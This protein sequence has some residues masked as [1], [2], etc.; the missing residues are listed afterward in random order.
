MKISAIIITKNEE[1]Q[2]TGCIDSLKFTDEIVVID[3]NSQ[4]NTSQ[5]AK[6]LGAKVYQ[7]GGLDF[8]YLRNYARE[9][10]KNQWLLYVDADERVSEEL[11]SEMIT[12]LEEKSYTAYRLKRSNFFLGRRWP[13]PEEMIRLIRKDSLIGWQGVLHETA[14]VTG[15]TGNLDN[16]LLHF[17]HRNLADMAE[18]TNQWSDLESQL[19]FKN[20]HPAMSVG[21]FIKIILLTF[22]KYYFSEKSYQTGAA[23]V[24][25][26]LYQSFSRFI[27]Y[28]KL[29]EKQNKFRFRGFNG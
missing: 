26:S 28:A 19:L 4:D 17:T 18:K 29:W 7:L 16:Q 21:R 8:S 3:N 20:N 25:E 27:T 11:A 24:V 22:L 9:K 2:I 1:D 5:I 12:S 13:K 6:R 23:G 10:A 15:T 14:I